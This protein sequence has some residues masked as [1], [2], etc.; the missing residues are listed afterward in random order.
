MRRKERTARHVQVYALLLLLGTAFIAIALGVSY[1]GNTGAG[2]SEA[3][4]ALV[5]PFQKAFAAK[6]AGLPDV[7]FTALGDDLVQVFVSD[8]ETYFY[9]VIKKGTL[10]LLEEGAVQ[11]PTAK[12]FLS[13]QTLTALQY[14]GIT[15]STAIREGKITLSSSSSV[16]SDHLLLV[17]ESIDL[18]TLNS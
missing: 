4:A 1:A 13:S 10:V 7:V 9:G 8:K 14:G 12:V 16:D 2:T 6:K 3:T 17:L 15:L 11:N 5:A 18:S